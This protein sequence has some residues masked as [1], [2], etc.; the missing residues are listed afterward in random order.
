MRIDHCSEVQ[1]T[2]QLKKQLDNMVSKAVLAEENNHNN[3]NTDNNEMIL[4]LPPAYS[5]VIQGNDTTA[6]SSTQLRVPDPINLLSRLA[7]LDF[8][9]YSPPNSTLS[10]DQNIVTCT[11]SN[12]LKDPFALVTFIHEQCSLPPKPMMRFKGTHIDM[13]QTT[14]VDFDLQL[15]L[16]TLL[17]LPSSIE[18]PQSAASSRRIQVSSI[19]SDE[20]NAS[21]TSSSTNLADLQSWA[22]KFVQHH[23]DNKR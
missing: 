8:P 15:N 6:S 13:H 20:S 4:D 16:I 18:P 12:L 17:D 9:K 5:N 21:S 22:R 2:T 3:S 7:Y 23:S 1:I 19:N 11:T 10:D 14:Q